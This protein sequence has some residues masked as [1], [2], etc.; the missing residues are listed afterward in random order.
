MTRSQVRLKA[1]RHGLV[2]KN[3]FHEVAIDLERG[4]WSAVDRASGHWGF[5]DAAF[6]VDR[7]GNRVWGDAPSSITWKTSVSKSKFGLGTTVLV[8][9]T[10]TEGYD[11][12]RMLSLRLYP[13]HAFIEIGWGV[14][15][16]FEYPLRVKTAEVLYGG[17]LFEGQTIED[18][19]VLNSG[20]GAEA[21]TVKKGWEIEALNGALLTCRSNGVRRSMVAGGL[22]YGEFGR[23]VELLDGRKFWN[24]HGEVKIRYPGIK[25]LNLAVF[26]PQGKWIEPGA[27]YMSPDTFY[28][29]FATANPFEALEAYGRALRT[30][31]AA[32]PNTYDFPTLCGWMVSTKHLGEG[33]PIN[34]SVGLVEQTRIARERGFMKYTPLAVRLEPD[35][36][37]QGNYGDTQQGWWDDEHWAA[38]APGDG[39]K[40]GAEPGSLRKPYDTFA[41][42]CKAVA[43]LG[44]LVETYF[45]SSMPSND[46]ARAHPRWMLNDDISQLHVQHA[47]HR[48]LVRY[49]YTNPGFR[50]HCLK[51]WRR[52]RKAGL[53]GVKFDY[54][55]TAWNPNGGFDDK[56]FTTTSAYRELFRLCREGLGRDAFIHERNLGGPCHEHAQLLDVTAGI[57][58]IQ[59][60]WWDSSH[61]EPEMA[62][63]MGLRWYKARSVFLYYPDGKSFFANGKPLPAYKRRAF[64][65]LIAFLSG[66]LEIGTSIGSM[67]DEMFRDTTR[68]FPMLGGEK[69]PRPVDLLTGGAHPAVYLYSVTEDWHQVLLVNNSKSGRKTI[70]APLSGNHV[71]TGSLGLDRDARYHAFDFWSQTYLGILKGSAT[72]SVELRGG[73]VAMVSVRKVEAHPQVLST[74]RHIMQGMMECHDI[75]WSGKANVLSGKVDVVGGE[76][77]VLVLAGNGR[78]VTGCEGAEVRSRDGGLIE[79][80]FNAAVNKALPFRVTFG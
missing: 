30:A 48:P 47:H 76:E 44:G 66:R 6:R 57:V 36:Y 40:K 28:L 18:P 53:K 19:R 11:P 63:R 75:R 51:V 60:V 7:A 35:T 27:T 68:L 34:N 70:S 33:K 12:V 10:P 56:R 46:F 42:F 62:S 23:R 61:F 77:F 80:V 49:D 29:D 45:Q 15:N 55:E 52:L 13:D 25:N 8:T 58:D 16:R 31:N 78:K 64:L 41:K 72:L 38:Y 59:R 1:T 71:E 43:D 21:N 79:L 32:H 9:T 50:A 14:R 5:K 54:P 69:S 26:D 3:R 22:A 2:L 74:N 65:T 67:T 4:V 17:L 73:E 20:A 39:H 24:F 37:C